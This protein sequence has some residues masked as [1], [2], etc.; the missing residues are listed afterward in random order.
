MSLFNL[1]TNSSKNPEKL[2]PI[3]PVKP[4]ESPARPTAPKP[5]PEKGFFG[6]KEFL[7]RSELR[8]KLGKASGK[9]PGA[10]TFFTK[11]Q[12][13][14]LEKEVFG[15]KF[16][17]YTIT[18]EKFKEGLKDLNKQKFSAETSKEKLEIDRRIRF[19]KQLGGE[20]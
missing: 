7:T 16:G 14:K 20:K 19:L 12:R 11:E 9:I 3:K 10:G 15:K 5:L 1:F 13:I 6:N 2:S 4:I 17:Q 18:P 8:E